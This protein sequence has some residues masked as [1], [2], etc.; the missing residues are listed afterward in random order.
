VYIVGN[1]HL[2]VAHCRVNIKRA[3]SL[4]KTVGVEIMFSIVTA[5]VPWFWQYAFLDD[6]GADLALECSPGWR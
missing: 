6:T 2:V 1:L 5:A 4:G 3:S